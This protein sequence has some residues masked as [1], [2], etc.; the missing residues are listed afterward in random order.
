[1]RSV[2]QLKPRRYEELSCRF[3][4]KGQK[5]WQDSYEKHAQLARAGKLFRSAAYLFGFESE[6]P[7]I[8]ET[9]IYDPG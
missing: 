3:Y 4:R 8:T 6:L 7:I 2:S 5:H 1:M 9:S